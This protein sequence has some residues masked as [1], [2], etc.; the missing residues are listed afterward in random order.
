M[1]RRSLSCE[2][3]PAKQISRNYAISALLAG[4]LIKTDKAAEAAELLEPILR[5]R[6]NDPALWRLAADAWGYS[7]NLTMAHLGRGEALFLSGADERGMD[8]LR[9]A[10][11]YSK[12]NFPLH[13]RISARLKEMETISK[14]RF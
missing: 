8:Q 2:R 6:T 12:D 13:S 5:Q 11:D 9:Y 3:L 10:L 7:G 4:S 1:I 14:E